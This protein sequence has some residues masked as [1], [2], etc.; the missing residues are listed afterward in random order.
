MSENS[1][2]SSF[3]SHIDEL[4]SR[5]FKILI[6]FFGFT[7]LFIAFRFNIYYADHVAVLYPYPDV[8]RNAAAQFIGALESHLLP[9][10]MQIIVLKPADAIVADFYSAMFLSLL[11]TMPIIVDQLGK[12]ILPALKKSE[13]DAITKMTVPAALL[14]AAGA[15]IGIWIVAP[16]MFIIFYMFDLGLGATAYLSLSSFVSFVL[17]YVA[18]FGLSFELPVIM[19]GLTRVG[20]IKSEFWKKNWRYAVVAALVFGMIFSPGAFGFTMVLMALPIII[21]YFGGIYFA[22]RVE[23]KYRKS[24]DL[25]VVSEGL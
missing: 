17:I 12:F 2:L 21:L 15:F 22:R 10:Q 11:F 6:P 16:E 3:F 19:V 18:S 9:P 7:V 8:Y 20:L 13:Q 24:D 4:R 14:F 25:Q 23:R 5:F 1:L